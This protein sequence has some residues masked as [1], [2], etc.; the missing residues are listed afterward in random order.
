LDGGDVNDRRRLK[1]KKKRDDE[2]RAFEDIDRVLARY[3]LSG[4][5]RADKLEKVII[6]IQ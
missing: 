4:K 6:L 3:Q 1:D 5:N 2:R